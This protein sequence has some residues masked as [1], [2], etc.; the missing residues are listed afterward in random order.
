MIALSVNLNKV[1][2]IRNS[3]EGDYPSVT[4]HAGTC[5]EAGAQGITVHPRPDQRHIR[6]HDVFELATLVER[7]PDVEY[8]IEGNP[9]A[10][11]GGTYP[12]YLHL[13]EETRP[14]QATLVPDANDQ[15]T[16]DHG[17]DLKK[18]H[19][20]LEP[21]IAQL[22]ALNVRVSL[23]MDPDPEQI[24]LAR[25]LGA[26]RIELYTG[27]YAAAW[28]DKERLELLHQQYVEASAYA[29]DIGLGVNAGHDLNLVNLTRFREMPG[30]LEVSIGHALTV[31]SLAMGM[32]PAVKAY[33][34]VLA[35][36]QP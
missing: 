22:R 28:S 24:K 4:A 12:G 35:G 32:A 10:G 14:H 25:E 31:D 21:V 1:A 15:L 8:N 17:F 20:V 13:V 19:G 9:F 18:N 34:S 26:D 33:L 2:L 29:T 7:H 16:S 23:F 11:A 5:I 6:P 27:P 36:H 3:R 30:L